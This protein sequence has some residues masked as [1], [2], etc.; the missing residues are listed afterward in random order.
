[1]PAKSKKQF[2]FMQMIAHQKGKGDKDGPSK[3]QAKEFVAGQSPKGLPER[4]K[5]K[6]KRK[7]RPAFHPKG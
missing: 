6:V 3:D 4:A 5:E 7:K 1:M 2:N